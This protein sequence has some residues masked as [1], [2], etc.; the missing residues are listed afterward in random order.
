M[1]MMLWVIFKLVVILLVL[2]DLA[3]FVGGLIDIV[4]PSKIKLLGVIKSLVVYLLTCNKC[5]SFWF[6][7]LW[8]GDLFVSAVVAMSI[9]FIML[10]KSRYLRSDDV[11]LL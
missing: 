6:S 11:T 10:I 8:S 4:V 7:L 3:E 5:F 1:M 9:S 2:S